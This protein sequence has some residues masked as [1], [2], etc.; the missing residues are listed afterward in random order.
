MRPYTAVCDIEEVLYFS[1]A[2]LP[3]TAAERG[4]NKKRANWLANVKMETCMADVQ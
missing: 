3:H 4:D 2:F 1:G